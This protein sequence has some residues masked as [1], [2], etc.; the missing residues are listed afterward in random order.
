M[1]RVLH[2]QELC[3]ISKGMKFNK[4]TS[5]VTYRYRLGDEWL[6]C[7]SAEKHLGVLAVTGLT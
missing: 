2:R 7:S 6:E 1:Q 5:K 4:G 3:M